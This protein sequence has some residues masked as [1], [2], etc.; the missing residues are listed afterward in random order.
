MHFGELF[1]SNSSKIGHFQ[2]LRPRENQHEAG[3]VE[4]R[5][6][7]ALHV[8]QSHSQKRHFPRWEIKPNVDELRHMVNHRY[9]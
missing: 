2:G 4:S 6:I 9:K 8:P 7:A 5:Q 3:Q 1:E